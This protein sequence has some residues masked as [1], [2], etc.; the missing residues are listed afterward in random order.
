MAIQFED[1]KCPRLERKLLEGCQL[2]VFRSGDTSLLSRVTKI[3]KEEP[4]VSEL[5]DSLTCLIK[6]TEWQLIEDKLD[7]QKPF[8]RNS[9]HRS[10]LEQFVARG[11]SLGF[12]ASF[13]VLRG[14]LFDPNHN[15]EAY[16]RCLGS[17]SDTLQ[18]LELEAIKHL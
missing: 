15:I 5:S 2:G 7:I 6:K 12:N 9:L 17:F 4:I 13:S 3:D 8:Y 11:Y 10:A 16:V 1:I 14:Y 18:L